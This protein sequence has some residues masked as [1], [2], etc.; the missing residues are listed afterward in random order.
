MTLLTE[1]QDL[2]HPT[3]LDGMFQTVV[4]TASKPM[5]PS[6]IDSVYVS[7]SLP[8]GAGS[9]FFG[10][11]TSK[12]EG[13]RAMKGTVIMTDEESRTPRILMSGIGYTLIDDTGPDTGAAD[14]SSNLCSKF[15]GKPDIELIS[16]NNAIEVF[17][18]STENGKVLSRRQQLMQLISHKIPEARI[19]EIGSCQTDLTHTILSALCKR[20]EK[21]PG[22]FQYTISYL[23]ESKPET[24]PEEL[25]KWGEYLEYRSIDLQI[26]PRDQGYKKGS[27][28]VIFLHNP[29]SL[30]DS[31]SV[32]LG[33][34]RRLLLNGGKVVVLEDDETD[35][36]WSKLLVEHGFSGIDVVLE[37]G[38][39][40]TIMTTATS[41]NTSQIGKEVVVVVPDSP[42]SEEHSKT[43]VHQLEGAGYVP[44]VTTLT[45]AAEAA[46]SKLC[47]VLLEASNESTLFNWSE[48]EFKNVQR[49]ILTSEGCLWVTRGA[50]FSA[51]RPQVSPVIGLFRSIRSED[52]GL[53]LHTLDLS[54]NAPLSEVFTADT[55]KRTFESIFVSK[56]NAEE[57]EFVEQ[58]GVVHVPRVMEDESLSQWI[59][60][61]CNRPGTTLETYR[62]VD[63]ALKVEVGVPGDVDSLHFADD[64]SFETK[65]GANE[66][67][68]QVQAA[69][70]TKQ[71]VMT[72]LGQT[73]TDT[74]GHDAAGII[75]RV[76]EGVK[77]WK[78][79]DKVVTFMPGALRNVIRVSED[80]ITKCHDSNSFEKDV[81]I[82]KDTITA[83]Y[84]L[85]E[86]ARSLE[87]SEN[88]L[89]FDL[90]TGLTAAIME[91][92]GPES[93]FYVGKKLA[94]DAL[95]ALGV[96]QSQLCLSDDAT[97]NQPALG[98]FTKENFSS[99]IC[100]HGSTFSPALWDLLAEGNCAFI[101]TIGMLQASIIED[102]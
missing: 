6:S 5:V 18:G 97:L 76:G 75:V 86:V 56:V 81:T 17:Q 57:F 55:I 64:L 16:A 87:E 80:T 20:S 65:L 31:A 21:T 15:V 102:G 13:L 2:I 101:P 37:E 52:S 11:A 36:D 95:L 92:V 72:L 40:R 84:A 26:D 46:R 32:L 90:D 79:G 9:E 25:S 27:F 74:L 43:L 33:N 22:F 48:D 89:L 44:R 100:R 83:F 99:I 67:E 71:D 70:V 30:V 12:S 59:E 54:D 1:L 29:L 8:S 35:F 82:P 39:R 88:V 3:T 78:S 85:R 63:R 77:N 61:R 91:V 50:Q 24:V 19:L 7:S 96:P 98:S 94:E 47:I 93:V 42:A 14:R 69:A 10:V 4:L 66:V 34:L 58:G 68:I 23:G 60:S 73:K 62:G 49:L 41:I 28:S 45:S 53:L 51:S 38:N